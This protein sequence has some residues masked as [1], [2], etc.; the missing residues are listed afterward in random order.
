ME[1]ESST[2][3]IN[4]VGVTN[5]YQIKKMVSPNDPNKKRV[6]TN[7]WNLQEEFYQQDYQ[8]N[9]LKEIAQKFERK[10]IHKLIVSQLE[11]KLGGYKHQDIIKKINDDTKLIKLNEVIDKL[12]A[13][14]LKCF[15]CSNDMH[16]L[17][18]IVREMNQWTLDRIDNSKGHFT[19][20]V[21][22]SCLECNLKRRKQNSDKFLFTKQ[23]KIVRNDF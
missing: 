2:K 10:E 12:I 8:L 7:K 14:D 22:V 6:I 3:K 5:R 20:N 16:I 19:D 17:Y 13:C 9:F 15:Y 18:K 1:E 23:M 21:V 11:S 4:I